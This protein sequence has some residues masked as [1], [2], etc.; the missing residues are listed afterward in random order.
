MEAV[1]ASASGSDPFTK[2]AGGATVT[3]G[4]AQTAGGAR[5]GGYTAK[6]RE[7]PGFPGSGYW[8]TFVSWQQLWLFLFPSSLEHPESTGRL[9][10]FA[11]Y[12]PTDA[13]GRLHNSHA[14]TLS[15]EPKSAFTQGTRAHSDGEIRLMVEHEVRERLFGLFKKPRGTVEV[16][17]DN[18][19][20]VALDQNY[21]REEVKEILRPVATDSDG[22][23]E[24]AN[25]LGTGLQQVIL[26]NQR[27]R[28]QAI[29]KDGKAKKERGP[30]VPFQ[31]HAHAMLT[32]GTQKKKQN[33]QEEMHT[34]TKRLTSCTLISGL[35]EQNLSSQLMANVALI[36]SPGDVDD[37]WDRYCALR[38]VGKASYVKARNEAHTGGERLAD[39]GLSQKHACGS[40]LIACGI[41][42]RHGQH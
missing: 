33:E 27:R 20:P 30:R 5:D 8:I 16:I 7:V 9:E 28:L 17:V 40:S 24:F 4:L 39:S 25:E 6:V 19:L 26:A 29:L 34:R 10:L 12:G 32:K 42:K 18:L 15:K 31:S 11:R 35:E 38:H 23:M 2:T 41:V 21:T 1:R 37:K 13:Q 36:R 14:G 3:G 22:N